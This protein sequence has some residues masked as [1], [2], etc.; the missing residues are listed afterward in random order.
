MLFLRVDK[1]H[2]ITLF[3]FLALSAVVSGLG[4]ALQTFVSLLFSLDTSNN[5][6]CKYICA[7]T[8]LCTLDRSFRK[9]FIYIV[10]YQIQTNIRF[11]SKNKDEE[12]VRQQSELL[13]MLHLGSKKLHNFQE[14]TK[15]FVKFSVW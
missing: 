9:Y 13:N 8:V 4:T 3:L 6:K 5:F 15:M 14:E 7:N 2:H 1:T 11:G 12:E 10:L